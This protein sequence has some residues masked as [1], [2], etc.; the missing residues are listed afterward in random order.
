[1]KYALGLPLTRVTMPVNRLAAFMFVAVFA[2]AGLARAEDY[3]AI[4]G[5]IDA[6]RLESHVRELSSYGSRVPG[7]PGHEQARQYV[8]SQLERIFGA[9]KVTTQDL[10]LGVPVDEG[11]SIT[12]AG[13]TPAPLACIWP[14]LVQ[15]STLPPDGLAAPLVYGK[16]GTL[17]DLSGLPVPDSIVLLDFDSGDNWLRCAELG[18]SAIIFRETP[19][20]SR[21]EAELKFISAPVGVPR[22]YASTAV[23]DELVARCGGRAGTGARPYNGTNDEGTGTGARPYNDAER[24]G[25]AT[26]G[27]PAPTAIVK[28]RMTWKNVTV[29][30]VI[31]S[32]EGSDPVL[33]WQRAIIS[34]PYDSISAVPAISPGSEN[35]CSIAGLLELARVL[36]QHPPKRSVLLVASA[37][38][39]QTMAGVTTFLRMFDAANTEQGYRRQAIT[40][41]R[42]IEIQEARLPQLEQLAAKHSGCTQLPD[43]VTKARDDV[44]AKQKRIAELAAL[45]R[46]LL[47]KDFDNPA[48]AKKAELDCTRGVEKAHRTQP[49]LAAA[50]AAMKQAIAD[51]EKDIFVHR[52]GLGTGEAAE[53][54]KLLSADQRN[55]AIRGFE[56]EIATLKAALK[57]TGQLAD[58]FKHQRFFTKSVIPRLEDELDEL[59]DSYEED[60]DARRVRRQKITSF[61]I[62]LDLAAGSRKIGLF[63]RGGY[64]DNRD[65]YRRR[66]YV[67][68]GRVL[69]MIACGSEE[70]FGQARPGI[71]A[72][73]GIDPAECFTEAISG[74]NEETI[75]TYFPEQIALECEPA[76]F[77][78][79][80]LSVVTCGDARLRTDTPHDLP[81][82]LNYADLAAQIRLLAPLLCEIARD[83]SIDLRI[84]E[85]RRLCNPIR[86]TVMRL[87]QTRNLVPSTPVP[88]AVAVL[89]PTMPW[90]KGAFKRGFPKPLYGVHA[91]AFSV[92]DANGACDFGHCL[93]NAYAHLEAFGL[94]ADT[95]EIDY[96]CDLGSEGNAKY[97]FSNV[98]VP[99]TGGALTCV[100]FQCRAISLVGLI[101]PRYLLSLQYI[102]LLD[103]RTE[104]EP[105]YYG[106]TLALATRFDTSYV[107]P[108]AVIYVRPGTAFKATMSLGQV[109]KRLV[110]INSSADRP[111]GNGFLA[112]RNYV[113][114]Q[115]N[116]R[117][118]LDIHVLDAQRLALLQENGI[119]STHLQ[120][121]H[122]VAG[123]FLDHARAAAAGNDWAAFDRHA[124][125]A[126][127]YESRVYPDL[128]ATSN[129]VVKGV[130]F[131]LA[132]VVPFAFFMERLLFAFADVRWRIACVAAVFVI[133]LAI[134]SFVHPAMRITMTPFLIFL[135]F[136]ILLLGLLVSGIIMGKFN[137]EL[138]RMKGGMAA[139]RHADVNRMSAAFA[140][141]N[142]GVSYMRRRKIKT[143]LTC[144]TLVLLTFTVLSFTSIRSFTRYNKFPLPWDA[145]YEGI[146]Y[147]S[148]TWAP[149]E[150]NEF[151]RLMM[152]LG[153]DFV[154]APRA[155]HISSRMEDY[156]TYDV[157][158]TAEIC[159]TTHALGFVGLSA[160]EPAVTHADRALKAGRWLNPGETH[161][162]LI[163]EEMAAAF[164]IGEA[165]LGSARLRL[166][167][168]QFAVVGIFRQNTG[169][170]GAPALGD[171]LD[172][173]DDPLMPA[174]FQFNRPGARAVGDEIETVDVALDDTAYLP[175]SGVVII[176]FETAVARGGSIRSLAA[177]PR[178]PIDGGLDAYL[179]RLMTGW[180]VAI[181]AGVRGADAAPDDPPS[182]YL[183]SSIG[184][185]ALANVG[186]LLLPITIAG[187]I[188]LN[189]MLGSVYEREKEIWTYS[190]VGLS[191]VHISALFIAESCVY[192]VIGCI[193]GYLLGQVV[194][195]FTA[196]QSGLMVNYSSMS[197]V[198]AVALVMAVTVASSLYPASRAHKLATPDIARTWQAGEPKGDDWELNLP[199][200]IT[201]GEAPAFNAYMKDFLECHSEESVGKFFTKNVRHELRDGERSEAGH[202]IKFGCWLAPYDFGVSQE[203]E[204]RTYFAE[205]D[206]SGIAPDKDEMTFKMVLHRLSGDDASWW[207][208]NRVFL[209]TLRKT[210]LIW[211]VLKPADREMY[212]EMG[213]KMMG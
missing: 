69:R 77:V 113:L 53:K 100:V 135:A 44:A 80:A 209:N 179:K 4:A 168:D 102:Q 35:A 139:L 19:D 175:A 153:G 174:N 76:S 81:G 162:C 163:P 78:M 59:E 150:A 68:L 210:F 17:E 8:Q 206:E 99:A 136:A 15:T 167:G 185:S 95:G 92:A 159:R 10:T 34:A 97:N 74:R 197:T 171:V 67:P 24:E 90:G 38:R 128:I 183:Y 55:A 116:H 27:E 65:V 109:G 3:R 208:T 195:H 148:L 177:V 61:F 164:G 115:V 189:T 101:D 200:I 182:A 85:N 129:D 144:V 98:N 22:F 104:T 11:A 45:I 72:E 151:D 142:L 86:C 62:S 120:R 49:Q 93:W 7:Y 170:D 33:K 146:M 161:A 16:R 12:M 13:G 21:T 79:P 28:A 91:N 117:V 140:A 172:L 187:L 145:P 196:G 130:I 66:E 96:A 134:L 193:T 51:R 111:A 124:R 123:G 50:I 39:Y 141:F 56:G 169:T 165:E 202:R 192:A 138:N 160:N 41:A 184:A 18:A 207:R 143:T 156:Q 29:K 204:L 126:W 58:S 43:A 73:L 133:V 9:E 82:R 110:L 106:Y 127:A 40:L 89:K 186:D 63:N 155:W 203:V 70:G 84:P 180:S 154:V 188:I 103:A 191:P 212:E 64:E 176:P 54:V 149:L 14:N 166:L 119:V 199:F 114:R 147:R 152:E 157:S 52:T 42:E 105:Q 205:A 1:M 46:V 112:D 198:F 30:N 131:Y 108:A 20:I 47:V 5:V 137:V 32:I 75:E 57:S 48:H 132:L 158:T 60:E 178:G 211:R 190:S 25:T 125:N 107:E 37:S 26:V 2:W 121:L 118:A 31:A 201:R 36:R 181:Y 71:C 6:A 122:E 94:N 23:G 87:D 194:T 88:G 83:Q 173:N 213:R